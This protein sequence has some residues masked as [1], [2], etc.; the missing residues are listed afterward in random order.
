M[1]NGKLLNKHLI[2]NTDELQENNKKIKNKIKKNK[3]GY[4]VLEMKD[5]KDKKKKG[6]PEKKKKPVIQN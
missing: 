1:F 5:R 3:N 2:M 4:K 6:V